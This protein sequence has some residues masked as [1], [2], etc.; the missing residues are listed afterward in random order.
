[1]SVQLLPE[2]HSHGSEFGADA[3]RRQERRCQL[4]VDLESLLAAEFGRSKPEAE[5]GAN[6]GGDN[7]GEDC[8]AHQ[9]RAAVHA[10]T[11]RTNDR[12]VACTI[13]STCVQVPKRMDHRYSEWFS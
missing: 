2:S 8:H 6:C 5:R 9:P 7:C 12:R 1:M 4:P 10:G 3:C 13:P 11:L